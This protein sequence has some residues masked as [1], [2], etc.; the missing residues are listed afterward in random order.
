M[1]FCL[2]AD[3]GRTLFGWF[4]LTPEEKQA[5]LT[6]LKKL[7]GEDT[8]LNMEGLRKMLEAF[9]RMTDLTKMD[10]RD[11]DAWRNVANNA[12]QVKDLP[13]NQAG[14]RAWYVALRKEGDLD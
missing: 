3:G 4:D 13:L 11:R 14:R 8:E 12:S 6:I 7:L 2:R 10:D 5:L 1:V 9:L